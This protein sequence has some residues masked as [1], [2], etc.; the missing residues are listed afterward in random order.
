MRRMPATVRAAL[1]LVIALHAMSCGESAPPSSPEAASWADVP[2]AEPA[3]SY[4]GI[5]FGP[6]DL[7]EGATTLK[8]GPAPF[9][10]SIDNSF[11][12]T[13]LA[14]RIAAARAKRFRLVL[15]MTGGP[16]NVITNGKFDLA[17][18]KARMN[19]L[20]T[21]AIKNAVADGVADGTIVG[22]VLLDEPDTPRWG[23]VITKPMVDEMAAYAKTIFPTM[24]MGIT[25]AVR[26]FQW[27]PGERFRVV[28]FVAVQ[29]GW[30]YDQGNVTA[31]REKVLSFAR[32]NGVA[33]MF[34]LNILNGGVTDKTGVWDCP[35][36][37]GKGTKTPQCRMTA[38][39]VR[40][41]GQAIGP[42]GCALL[43]WRYDQAFM[44][45][46]ANQAA[47]RDVASMLNGKPQRSCR[48]A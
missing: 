21:T 9:T 25:L 41:W 34:S 2:A 47:F 13:S 36:T 45:N 30:Y 26:G 38:D 31:W 48:R 44:A 29:F 33:P 22:N 46:A 10:M 17:K 12:P 6:Y 15:S 42:F 39:Q 35:S 27:R 19:Q 3:A 7:W 24:P 14:Q 20:N 5:P 18:W 32:T 4:S 8:W 37:G 23:G 43:M 11:F 40:T 16:N 1:P 28:D